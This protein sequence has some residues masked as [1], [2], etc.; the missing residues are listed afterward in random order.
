MESEFYREEH[1]ENAFVNNFKPPG[2]SSR[3]TRN[4]ED[5]VSVS[6]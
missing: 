2:R 4:N 5:N 6:K 3:P 1:I